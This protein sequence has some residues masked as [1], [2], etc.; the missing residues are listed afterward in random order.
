MS[1]T[2]EN[3]LININSSV[4]SKRKDMAPGTLLKFLSDIAEIFKKEGAEGLMFGRI[5]DK[6]KVL[7]PRR[8]ISQKVIIPLKDESQ[9]SIGDKLKHCLITMTDPYDTYGEDPS[10]SVRAN[11]YFAEYTDKTKNLNKPGTWISEQ[12]FK[13][14]AKRLV[15]FDMDMKDNISKSTFDQMSSLD[16]EKWFLESPE[17]KK[18]ERIVSETDPA[19]ILFTGNGIHIAYKMDTFIYSS[20]DFRKSKEA[21]A[22]AYTRKARELKSMTGYSFDPACK[23]INRIDRVP[24][25][26]NLKLGLEDSFASLIYMNKDASYDFTRRIVDLTSSPEINRRVGENASKDLGMYRVLPKLKDSNLLMHKHI[27]KELT[28]KKVFDHFGITKT[29][30]TGGSE[31]IPGEKGFITTR[32][33]FRTKIFEEW[34]PSSEEKIPSFRVDESSLIFHDFGLIPGTQDISQGDVLGLAYGIN[35]YKE[36]G[37]WPTS[38]HTDRAK[39][40]ALKIIGKKTEDEITSEVKGFLRDDKGNVLADL[41]SMLTG[42]VA[43]LMS[44]YEIIFNKVQRQFL[45]RDKGTVAPFKLFPWECTAFGGKDKATIGRVILNDGGLGNPSGPVA[46]TAKQVIDYITDPMSVAFT[47][48]GM[49]AYWDLVALHKF[50]FPVIDMDYPVLKFED[51]VFYHVRTGDVTDDYNGYAYNIR[52]VRYED[53]AKPSLTEAPLFKKLLISMIGPEDSPEQMVFRYILSQ[54]WLPAHGDSRALIIRGNGRNGKS[55]LN[56]VL[57][58]IMPEGIVLNTSISTLT[59]NSSED[60]ASRMGLL[61]KHLVLVGDSEERNLHKILKNIITGEAGITAKYLYKNPISFENTATLIFMANE[62][63]KIAEDVSAFLRRFLVIESKVKIHKVILNLDAKILKD[64]RIGVW[65]HIITSIEY[66]RENHGFAFPEEADWAKKVI[67]PMK[68]H[69]LN[70]FSTGELAMNIRPELGSVI[71]IRK[72]FAFY[73]EYASDTKVRQSSLKS[74]A[75]RIASVVESDAEIYGD[76]WFELFDK[77]GMDEQMVTVYNNGQLEYIV[78]AKFATPVMSNM[79]EEGMNVGIDTIFRLRDT[80]DTMDLHSVKYPSDPSSSILQRLKDWRSCMLGESK[81]AQI[82]DIDGH[83]VNKFD[84]V[85]D[86]DKSSDSD[87]DMQADEDA[88]DLL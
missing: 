56:R 13:G 79:N 76:H 8:I 63:P 19:Y 25:T 9:E 24:F 82:D 54:M 60:S 83:R 7:L 74:F 48:D 12:D 86:K 61:G 5:G 37:T 68:R 59:G 43:V 31:L 80:V 51:N 57:T 29:V 2:A 27:T 62:F 36:K 32:S 66:F 39:Q 40:V 4:G 67:I 69:L 81:V 52:G 46:A 17:F 15:Y 33:P 44:K 35:Y 72:M 3:R 75:T 30:L 34:V 16:K 55:T 50:I 21:Y 6:D 58:G 20:K 77:R 87:K 42:M 23:S 11:W 38:I 45:F 70:Q 47:S 78:N 10:I 73:G 85:G 88:F 64:E 49:H 18:I 53:L 71:N 65:K 26:Y 22:D 1:T 84:K 41:D 28:F 14:N